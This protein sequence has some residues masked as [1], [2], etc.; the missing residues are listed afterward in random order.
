MCLKIIIASLNPP[1][2]YPLRDFPH[3][4]EEKGIKVFGDL[5]TC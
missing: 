5:Q 2:P 3:K 4:R 1:N